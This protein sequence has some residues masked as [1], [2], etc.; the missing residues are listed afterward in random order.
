MTRMLTKKYKIGI[1]L[2]SN[3]PKGS[4]GFWCRVDNIYGGHIEINEQSTGL[5]H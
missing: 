4:L 2:R 3:I 5:N 1:K